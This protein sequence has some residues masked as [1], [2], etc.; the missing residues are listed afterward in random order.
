MLTAC[1][2]HQDYQDFL[3]LNIPALFQSDPN[4]LSS[5]SN[6]LSALWLLNCDPAIPY[7]IEHYSAKGRP[8]EF[9]PTDLFRSLVLMAKTRKFFGIT[10]WSQALRN[11]RVLAVLSGFYPDKTPSIGVFYAFLDRFWLEFD[12]DPKE[13]RLRLRTPRRKPR[14]K[15]SDKLKKGE[16]LPNKR[17]YVVSRLVNQVLKGRRLLKR[18]ERLIQF[19]FARC[20]VD[21]SIALRLIP[22]TTTSEDNLLSLL[23]GIAGDGTAVKTTAN[24]SGIK[25]CDCRNNGI[26]NCDCHRRF[27]DYEANWG[28]DSHNEIYF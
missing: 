23:A 12:N 26:Y 4:R 27:S 24:H 19:I 8:A 2:S 9:D 21:K 15:K 17:P 25:V 11:D 10:E 22:T 3:K 7:F 20:I 28:W 6:H 16:K 1:R 14:Q 18:P 5:F 13:R